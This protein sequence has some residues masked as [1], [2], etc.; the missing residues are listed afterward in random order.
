M[1]MEC[2]PDG[3]LLAFVE[4]RGK[5]DEASAR[6]IFK[7]IVTAIS[8]CH[9]R[10]IVHRD[11]K[12]ENVLFK[13]KITLHIKVVDF[14]IAGVC[15]ENQKDKVEAGSLAYMP[16]EVLSES[17]ADTTT[18]IDVWAIGCILFGMI[19]GKLPF[20]GDT[21]DEFAHA[22][23]KS[24]PFFDPQVPITPECRSILTKMLDKDPLKRLDLLELMGMD[25][26]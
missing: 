4:E 23:L 8:Y 9:S 25:Y 21:E 18:K 5:L 6:T 26:F 17:K 16:P 15:K 24:K 14:G 19:Y 13:D 22:I 20:W 11:L 3:E 1:I 12:M 10:G 2:A 7:Q